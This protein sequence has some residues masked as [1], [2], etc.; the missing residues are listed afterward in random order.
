MTLSTPMAGIMI[1]AGRFAPEK[2]LFGPAE[3][4]AVPVLPDEAIEPFE[5]CAGPDAFAEVEA[6]SALFAFA[7]P[8]SL[9]VDSFTNWNSA[10]TAPTA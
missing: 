9:G 6:L 4:Y 8:A 5:E 1:R 3:A 7:E 10:G 2:K